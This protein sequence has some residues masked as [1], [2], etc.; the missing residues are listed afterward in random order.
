MEF[1][2]WG[3]HLLNALCT[4]YKQA[5]CHVDTLWVGNLG[6]ENNRDLRGIIFIAILRQFLGDFD[7]Q[8]L[9]V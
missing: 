1:Q 7:F 2:V 4:L 9:L 6:S 3:I 8:A 5:S